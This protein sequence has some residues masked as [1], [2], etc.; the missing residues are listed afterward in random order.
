M[1][2]TLYI[3]LESLPM[4]RDAVIASPISLCT[5]SLLLHLLNP[6]M[7]SRRSETLYPNKKK[8]SKLYLLL[9]EGRKHYRMGRVYWLPS[10]PPRCC[11]P[12][13]VD[14]SAY[15]P[16]WG[17]GYCSSCGRRSLGATTMG[18]IFCKW[19]RN[20]QSMNWWRYL[21]FLS[22]FLSRSWKLCF[23]FRFFFRRE[24]NVRCRLKPGVIKSI[25]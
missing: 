5:S 9:S 4:G 18:L 14:V 11:C 19:S 6:F 16:G 1:L 23:F 20:W 22:V 25:W 24:A 17:G 15:I 12:N 13:P 10:P 7:S 2:D 3:V 21:C 8:N